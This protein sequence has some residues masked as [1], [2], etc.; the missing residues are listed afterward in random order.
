ME[1]DKG[2]YGESL[3]KAADLCEA[4]YQKLLKKEELLLIMPPDH[5]LA[6]AG[7]AE[8]GRAG[9]ERQAESMG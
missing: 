8:K 5:P 3:P 9:M 7:K 4:D 6:S 2:P 1:K